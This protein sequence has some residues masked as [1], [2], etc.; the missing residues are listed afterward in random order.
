MP[1]GANEQL[2]QAVHRLARQRDDQQAWETLFTAS[3][4]T[5]LATAH[6]I[7][8]GQLDLAADAAQEAFARVVRYCDFRKVPN[9]A[10][11][12]AYLR[13][14]CRHTAFDLRRHMVAASGH[15]PVS[16]VPEGPGGAARQPFPAEQSLLRQE[17]RRELM[18]HL[19][20]EE[21]QLLGMLAAERSL[22]EIASKFAIS[23]SNAGVRVH[24]LRA[25]LRKLLAE[26]EKPPG[27]T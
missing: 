26:E 4:P 27:R 8:G 5:A 25:K 7:L 12:L 21:Q 13:A 1:A 23:Y 15:Q 19:D 18:R 14:V 17:L 3:W 2:T 22:A 9:G 10:S 24:R 20:P 11:F 6:R 16:A